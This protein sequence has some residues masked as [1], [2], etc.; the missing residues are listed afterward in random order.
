MSRPTIEPIEP[1][2]THRT[3]RLELVAYAAVV[4]LTM[5]VSHFFPMGF[6]EP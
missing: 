4:I 5:L 2:K 1:D 3:T 6:A